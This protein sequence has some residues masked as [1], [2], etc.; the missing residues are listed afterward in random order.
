MSNI[1]TSYIDLPNKDLI[2]L[3]LPTDEKHL[4]SSSLEKL[5]IKLNNFAY[6]MKD[7]DYVKSHFL[8]EDYLI[9]C[10]YIKAKDK[11]FL[12]IDRDGDRSD[13]YHIEKSIKL[14]DTD[15][16]IIILLSTTKISFIKQSLR[17]FI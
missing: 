9:L 11:M 4:S 2:V 17:A 12:K 14:N 6:K 1:E 13:Y 16:L 15:P 7:T 5:F 8:F 3:K 10:A